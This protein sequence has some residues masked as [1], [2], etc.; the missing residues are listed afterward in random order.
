MTCSIA[1][2]LA[3][4]GSRRYDENSVGLRVQATHREFLK[5]TQLTLTAKIRGGIRPRKH[6]IISF[7]IVLLSI[8]GL[9]GASPKENQRHFV[10][11]ALS[12]R[13]VE[14]RSEDFTGQIVYLDF[15]SSW[16]GP[17][18]DSLELL[19]RL[20]KQFKNDQFSVIAI[21]LDRFPVDGRRVLEKI[22]VS[23][24]IASDIGWKVANLYG[25]DAVP[26]AFLI[27]K[28]GQVLSN[29][30]ELNENNFLNIV[31]AIDEELHE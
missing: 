30:P 8:A 26:A 7:L 19:G 25:I 23:Y 2:S 29:M 5:K 10:L 22:D 20:Q 14:I 15:W 17:C 3:Q 21:N 11:P 9:A 18:R 4:C 24:P 28:E 13:D 31:A 12:D 6:S 27:G 16:C 1:Q